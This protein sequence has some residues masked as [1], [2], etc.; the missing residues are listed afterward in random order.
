[1]KKSQKRSTKCITPFSRSTSSIER[2]N[3]LRGILDTN[4]QLLILIEP[5]PD[6][7]ASALVL[8]RILWKYVKRCVISYPGEISRL[9]NQAM[10]ELLKIPLVKF[11]NIDPDSFECKAI[12]DSQPHH[13]EIFSMFKYDIIIDHHPLVKK[14][15]VPFVDIRPDYGAT[16]TIMTEYLRTAKIRPTERLSTALLYGIK[17]DTSSFERNACIHDIEQFQYV[18]HYANSNLLWKIER[19]ELRF[20]DLDF[21]LKAIKQM[22]KV[23]KKIFAYLGKIDSPDICV[24][25]A[26]FF[27]RV[28][29][30]SWS[31]IAGIYDDKLIVI[32]RSDGIRKDAGKLAARAFAQY[33]SA[34]GHKV[35]ARAEISLEELK[36]NIKKINSYEI[37]DFVKNRLGLGKGAMPTHLT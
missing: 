7:I 14:Y 22:I 19:S 25:I 21:Y 15:D 37:E 18:F 10:V 1:M 35:A 26:D 3:S 13:Q 24:Q 9:E 28:H 23:R 30:I 4:K 12:V 16:A 32:F 34:G 11:D 20:K 2:L 27:M 33:G 6:S 8:K 31:F 29:T 5:D 17:S 36:K